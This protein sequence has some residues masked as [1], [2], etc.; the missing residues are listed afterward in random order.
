MKELSPERGLG[1]YRQARLRT[2]VAA[3]VVLLVPFALFYFLVDRHIL[4]PEPRLHHP[5]LEYLFTSVVFGVMLAIGFGRFV[6]SHI[7]KLARELERSMY[8]V[9]QRE[10]ERDN[11]QQELMKRLEEERELVKEK[12]QFESQ[13]AEYEKY[14]GLAQLALGAAHEINNPLLGILSH[15]EL[16]LKDVQAKDVQS[17]EERIEIEQCIE[18]A[19][20]ISA[21]IKGLIDYARPG[22]LQLG[23]LNLGRMIDE[24]FAFLHHQPLFRRIKLEKKVQHDLPPIT[25][26]AN[27]ISQVLMNLLLNSA[28]AMPDGGAITISAE[29]V[30]FAEKIEFRIVDTGQGIPADILPHIFEPFFTT[31]RGRGT[32]LGLSISETYIH[33]HG[34]DI[35]AESIPNRGTTVKIVLPIRQEGRTVTQM[36]EVIV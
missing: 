5:L 28:Q 21:T 6:S 24:T 1:I 33:S 15:L 19:K 13:L 2:T 16:E 26:D 25:A 32:G 36:D 8:A 30:K 20:R 17:K 22:P 27:Q 31:K 3:A 14:A 4:N 29:K 34:G 11:A 9:E 18:G 12:L 23:K 7:L 35:S 10:R